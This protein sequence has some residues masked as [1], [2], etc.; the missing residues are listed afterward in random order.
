MRNKLLWFGLLCMIAATLLGFAR[1]AMGQTT[2]GN[3]NNSNNILSSS[4]NATAVKI[5]HE[6]VSYSR[7]LGTILQ[8]C[9]ASGN[10]SLFGPCVSILNEYNTDVK[11]ILM[12]HRT[13]VNQLIGLG[14]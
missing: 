12:E 1:L 2:A 9:G 7:V 5:A 14:P 3:S 13:L 8:N 10:A 4:F 6:T 11:H